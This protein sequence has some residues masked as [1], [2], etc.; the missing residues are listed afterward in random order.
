MP[1]ACFVCR[2]G[3][4]FVVIAITANSIQPQSLRIFGVYLLQRGV[5]WCTLGP[6]C[7]CHLRV[8]EPDSEQES[9]GS[10]GQHVRTQPDLFH[11]AR[12]QRAGAQSIIR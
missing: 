6:G 10:S 12:R 8:V 4:F 2:C 5:V 9:G 7:I 1:K 3:N 11:Y